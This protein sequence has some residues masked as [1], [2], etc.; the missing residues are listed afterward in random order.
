MDCPGGDFMELSDMHPWG[1]W[2]IVER[3][4]PRD[5]TESGLIIPEKS[6]QDCCEV[7]VL[8]CGQEAAIPWMGKPGEGFDAG[9]RLVIGQFDGIDMKIGMGE[10]EEEKHITLI[11]PDAVVCLLGGNHASP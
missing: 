3:D 7:T 8:K 9:Q 2:M 6:K 5:T 10:G 1:S 11:Q 4:Q